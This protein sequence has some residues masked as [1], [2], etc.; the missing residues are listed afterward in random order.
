MLVTENGAA[1]DDLVRDGTRVDDQDRIDYLRAHLN[2]ALDAIEHG[3]PLEGYFAWT[4]LDN[5]EWAHGY[6][7]RFGL[8]EVD[9][10]TQRR[11]P[12]SSALW[13]AELARTG[14][15]LM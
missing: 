3:V 6:V 13:Y 7:P 15:I 2:Q 10:S 4:L 8:V 9:H 5:F 12:K 11:T 14:E 1:M